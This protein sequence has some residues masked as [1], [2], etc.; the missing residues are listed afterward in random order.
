[1]SVPQTHATTCLPPFLL[2][3]GTVVSLLGESFSSVAHM[4]LEEVATVW[5]FTVGAGK[6]PALY[7]P[8]LASLLKVCPTA[9]LTHSF[10]Q[11]QSD[12]ALYEP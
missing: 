6:Q 8:Y 4:L 1:M 11:T 5:P 10:T 9:S 3:A 2:P 7:K 12:P